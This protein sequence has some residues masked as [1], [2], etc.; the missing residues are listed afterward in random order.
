MTKYSKS[1][2]LLL[3]KLTMQESGGRAGVRDI[4]LLDSAISS[5]YQTFDNK[6]LYPTKEEKAAKIG[7]AL[8][9]SHAFVDGNKRTGMLIMLSF[10]EMNG[11]HLKYTEQDAIETGYMVAK[12]QMGY[13]ELLDWINTHKD[14][15]YYSEKDLQL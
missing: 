8:I 7:Y 5:A 2:I 10:L 4:A 3:Y 9:T 11:V 6:E 13:I 12:G 14:K 15:K 1:K